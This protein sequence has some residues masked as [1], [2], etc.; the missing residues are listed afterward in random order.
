MSQQRSQK[1]RFVIPESTIIE[2]APRRLPFAY[3][4]SWLVGLLGVALLLLG[5]VLLLVGQ[6]RERALTQ[7]WPSATAEVTERLEDRIVYSWQ[8]AGDE[9]QTM[10]MLGVDNSLRTVYTGEVLLRVDLCSV[11]HGV[12]IPQVGEEFTVWYNPDNPKQGECLPVT[13]ES[14][15]VFSGLGTVLL[16]LGGWFVLRLFHRAGMQAAQR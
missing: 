6:A 7:D 8:A 10:L 5:A 2:E 13:Q 11:F 14:A 9:Q 15:Q 12:L 4:R 16:A 3:L 1:Q